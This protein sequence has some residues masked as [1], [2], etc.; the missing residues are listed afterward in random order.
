MKS[1]S[2]ITALVFVFNL[3]SAGAPSYQQAMEESIASLNQ[4][5]D[6]KQLL[7]VANRFERIARAEKDEWLPWYYAAYATLNRAIGSDGASE[8]DQLLDQ[9]QQ[10]LDEAT[11]VE[12]NESELV[13]L[14]GYVHT[15]RVTVDPANRGPQLAP[16]AT[17]TLGKAV[18]MNPD[19][20]RALF[21]LGQMQYGTAQ[22]FGADTAEACHLIQQAV[23]KYESVTSE[24]AL[25]PNWG[26][27]SAQRMSEQCKQ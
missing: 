27:K 2:L 25:M 21:L 20:P 23:A 14:Q 12:E 17:Q 19:N 16:L 15:I 7:A 10:Y 8:K 22:F 9:A 26:E 24:V 11:A 5:S 4:A 6:S 1:L 18:Q 3:A 13:A